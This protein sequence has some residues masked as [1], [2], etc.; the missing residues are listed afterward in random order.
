[1]VENFI[2]FVQE[3]KILFVNF[4]FSGLFGEQKQ[5]SR[6]FDSID[7]KTL[8]NGV[9]I[10]GSSIKGWNNIDN[11]DILLK[12]DLSQFFI[13]PYCKD[14]SITILC[15]VVDA[16][17]KSIYF[18]GNF[19]GSLNVGSGSAKNVLYVAEQIKSYFNSKSNIKIS[20]SY[21][22]GDIR[23]NLADLSKIAD[24]L[25]FSPTVQFTQGLE[26]FLDWASEYEAE[27]G[28]GYIKSVI[29][30]SSRGLMRNSSQKNRI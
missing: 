16:T 8:T 26:N 14:K 18:A 13:E 20:G 29:E 10:D 4:R 9:T 11:S 27:D 7:K 21:R 6:I 22:M 23:H 24:L 15:D 12:P 3:N 1:M 2:Q 17:E 19:V 30:L 25:D 5:I 28:S